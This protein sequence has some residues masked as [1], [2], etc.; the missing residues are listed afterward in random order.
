MRGKVTDILFTEDQIAHR[1][2][3]LA[4]QI[5]ADYQGRHIFAICLLKGSLIFTS[6][7]MRA[8]SVPC[9]VDIMRA[10][11]YGAGTESSGNVRIH[12]DLDRD[13][14]GQD[15]LI[16]EDIVDT[17]RT[18]HKTLS[19]LRDRQPNSIK[20][21]SFLDKPSRRVA[22]VPVDYVGFQIEDHFVVGYG[23]DYD[24]HYRHLPH[25]GILDPNG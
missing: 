14:S 1:V 15:V 3:E 22:D 12:I 4:D 18:L 21:C 5:S 19:I 20:I 2:K 25:I 13:I 10:S 17:G 11:S 7:L 23:L 16:V 9:S 6:D 24:E 8:L